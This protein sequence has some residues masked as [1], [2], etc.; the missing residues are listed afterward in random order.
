M[1]CFLNIPNPVPPYNPTD[2]NVLQHEQQQQPGLWL[3]PQ[4][5]PVQYSYQ[6]FGNSQLVCYRKPGEYNFR[7][8]V[9]DAVVP[10]LVNWYHNILG[11]AGMANLERSL[12]ANFYHTGIS[13][14][15]QD[16]VRNCPDC[17]RYK[18]QG[19]GYGQLPPREALCSMV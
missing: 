3:L 4:Q 1:D 9:P 10:H 15:C 12:N 13:S 7:I 5:D 19:A 16:L 8:F 2:Y 11:H 14:R 18:L 17:Q 6:Q